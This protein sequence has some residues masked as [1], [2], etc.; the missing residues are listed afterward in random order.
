MDSLRVRALKLALRHVGVREAPPGSNRGAL[1]DAWNTAAKVPTGTPWCSAF[2]TA[3]LEEAGW[4]CAIAKRASVGFLFAGLERQGLLVKRPRRGDLVAFMFDPDRWPDHVGFVARVLRL[5]PV[6]VLRTCE[7]NTSSGEAGS[8][9]DGGGVYRRRRV[10]ARASVRF[11]R[12]P[13]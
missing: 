2:A 10:I 11:A 12:I 9:S 4:K 1:I 8:Q 5:G 6:L 7:G 13:G 3:M